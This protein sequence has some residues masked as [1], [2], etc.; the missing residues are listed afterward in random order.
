[1][2]MNCS[3]IENRETSIELL[4]LICMFL[5]VLGHFVGNGLSQIDFYEKY[6]T[7]SMTILSF[8][9]VGVNCFILISG[10]FQIK[11]P[12][13]ALNIYFISAFYSVL[14]YLLYAYFINDFNFIKLIKSFF[15]ISKG[16][17]WFIGCYVQFSLLSPLINL[18]LYKSNTKMLILYCIL[19]SI[20]NLYLGYFMQGGVNPRG[21]NVMH[22][23]FIYVLGYTLAKIDF[24]IKS[25][26]LLCIYIICSLI[27]STLAITV[28][29]FSPDLYQ[30]YIFAYNNPL[31]IISSLSFFLFFIKHPIKK[32]VKINYLAIGSFAIYLIQGNIYIKKYIYQYVGNLSINN[33]FVLFLYL[34]LLACV[35][36]ILCA[37]FDILIRDK[38]FT[39]LKIDS[40]IRKLNNLYRDE[41]YKLK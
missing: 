24:K 16:G 32:I 25:I 30:T 28:Y 26:H 8:C 6:Q 21:F 4:R 34:I 14:L 12:I 3:R 36:V 17:L 13:S 40:F 18:A 38:I 41:F 1:M 31:I 11:S 19:L 20:I 33:E 7:I 2:N 9:I 37:L 29:N 23:I 15:S 22:F 10:F 5:I 39:F 35:I 27:L